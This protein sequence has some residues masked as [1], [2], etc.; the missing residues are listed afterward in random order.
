MLIF[1]VLFRGGF[2]GLPQGLWVR[3]GLCFIRFWNKDFPYAHSACFAVLCGHLTEHTWP[4]TA[5]PGLCP[6]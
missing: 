3:K 4:L 5:L 6:T 1:K 2:L